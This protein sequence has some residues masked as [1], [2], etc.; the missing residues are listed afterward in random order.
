MRNISFHSASHDS[1]LDEY[2]W[3]TFLS[4]KTLLNFKLASKQ[5]SQLEVPKT[6]SIFHIQDRLIHINNPQDCY[7]THHRCENRR[8]FDV[9]S[10][11]HRK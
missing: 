10:A 1:C 9:K 5:I 7:K 3:C 4:L 11:T 6:I 2:Q 8:V